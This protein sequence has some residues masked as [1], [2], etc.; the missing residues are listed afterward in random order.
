MKNIAGKL[1]DIEAKINRLVEE[2]NQLK[3]EN[4]DLKA[5]NKTLSTQPIQIESGENASGKMPE[6]LVNQEIKNTE[7]LKMQI[8]Q[9][10]ELI[11]ISIEKLSN[12]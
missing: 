12:S 6:T 4:S 8:D 11:D 10:V 3:R 1:S 7:Q 2:N 9:A 5:Q